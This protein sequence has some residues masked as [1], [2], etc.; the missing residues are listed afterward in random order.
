MAKINTI[1]EVLT[2][3]FLSEWLTTATYGSSW[4]DCQIH[5]DTSDEVIENARESNECR[6]DIWAYVLL[7]GGALNIIDVEEDEEYKVTLADIEK[8]MATF[9]LNCP[10]QWAA[11]MDRT[12]DIDDA[13]ALLQWVVFDELVY[14]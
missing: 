9:M 7:N 11:I 12:M 14:G 4:C 5:S 2:Q 1:K 8:A 10:N 6:E 13:D 3:G